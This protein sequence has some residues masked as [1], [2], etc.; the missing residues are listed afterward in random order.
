MY[1]R[2]PIREVGLILSCLFPSSSAKSYPFFV[3]RY[4]QKRARENAIFHE[5]W[6]FKQIQKWLSKYNIVLSRVV[7]N[8]MLVWFLRFLVRIVDLVLVCKSG[9]HNTQIFFEGVN[10]WKLE[11]LQENTLF[12]NILEGEWKCE[13]I[14]SD[15]QSPNS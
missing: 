6:D 1:V 7:I 8:S 15:S 5:N 11:T 4:R 12:L 9:S 13:N 2:A 10:F 14:S 3:P